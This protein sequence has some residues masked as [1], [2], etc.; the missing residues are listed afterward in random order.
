VKSGLFNQ[1]QLKILR[2]RARGLTQ[3]KVAKELG[4]SRA[5]IS[6]IEWRARRKLQKARETIRAYERLQSSNPPREERR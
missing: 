1:K 5:N 6:M 4:T 3:L 2:L